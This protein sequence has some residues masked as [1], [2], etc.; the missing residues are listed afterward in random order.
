[1]IDMELA[2]VQQSV[3][4]EFCFAATS[5]SLALSIST[6]A[7]CIFFRMKNGIIPHHTLHPKNMLYIGSP[8][9]QIQA[10]AFITRNSAC[11]V[12]E[13]HY[14]WPLSFVVAAVPSPF[15]A[16]MMLPSNNT[17]I[18]KIRWRWWCCCCR[19]RNDT[20]K[21]ESAHMNLEHCIVCYTRK[22]VAKMRVNELHNTHE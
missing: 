1:M 17:R 19:R 6:F 14:R 10:R 16:A 8:E 22:E 4:C 5:V 7:S 15:S 18:R 11:V 13:V 9:N 21:Q 3:H 12:A 20:W 2:S